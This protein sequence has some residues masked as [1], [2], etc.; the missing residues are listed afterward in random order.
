MHVSVKAP[1]HARRTLSGLKRASG[2]AILSVLLMGC[3]NGSGGDG[4]TSPTDGGTISRSCDGR[5]PAELGHCQLEGG[6]DCMG[7]DGERSRFASLSDGQTVT[8]VIG[9]Q[10]SVM[11]VFAMRAPAIE[12]GSGLSDWP[13]VELVLLDGTTGSQLAHFRSRKEFTTGAGGSPEVLQLWVVVDDVARDL[14][15]TSVFARGTV[16]DR[17]GLELCG[18]ARVVVGT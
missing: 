3:G 10:G 6:G 16:R 14:G 8:M 4:G 15:G 7:A 2:V 1:S 12:L 17:M 11:L 13:L 18:T 9:P 5:P